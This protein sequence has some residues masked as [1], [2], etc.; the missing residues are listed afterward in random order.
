MGPLEILVVECPGD[1]LK[2]E[3]ILTLTSA[4]DNGT[5][6]IIDVTFIHK[7]AMGRVDSYEL[8]ELQEH[9]LA[10]YDAVDEVRGLL[11]VRDIARIAER[12]SPDA[13]AILMVIEHAWTTRLE[14]AIR[15]ADARIIVHERI[16]PEIATAALNYRFPPQSF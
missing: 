5:L 6:R 14:Q 9:E 2:S 3:I 1:R 15:C 4:V 13:S 11:S 12:V 16:P 10:A 8:A 7:D